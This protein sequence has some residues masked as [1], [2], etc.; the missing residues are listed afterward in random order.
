MNTVVDTGD[1][2]TEQ[3][4]LEVEILQE[5]ISGGNSSTDY[6]FGL[7]DTYESDDLSNVKNVINEATFT[8]RGTSF[9]GYRYKI[10]YEIFIEFTNSVDN[11]C[12]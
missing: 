9:E 12:A 11:P 1:E 5:N 3:T 4:H 6:K 2:L 7:D 8:D 10:T